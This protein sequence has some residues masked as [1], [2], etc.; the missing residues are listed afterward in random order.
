MPAQP[1][2]ALEGKQQKQLWALFLRV[3]L[4]GERKRRAH[5]AIRRV[6]GMANLTQAPAKVQRLALRERFNSPALW[7]RGHVKCVADTVK[8][9]VPVYWIAPCWRQFL[10]LFR[11]MFSGKTVRDD[12][13]FASFP[14]Y[15]LE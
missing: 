2:H 7:P 6:G 10:K 1:L 8:P 15:R 9:K 14:R 5:L 13:V 11:D 12:D 4:N 3:Y